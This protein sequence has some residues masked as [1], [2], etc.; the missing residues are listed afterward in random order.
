MW[1]VRPR[2]ISRSTGSR[3]AS[4]TGTD[5]LG[6]TINVNRFF[7]GHPYVL[8]LVGQSAPA[9]TKS[10]MRETDVVIAV[11]ASL[12]RR[13]LDG[14]TLFRDATIIQ[15]EVDALRERRASTTALHLIGRARQTVRSVTA[16]WEA[17]GLG[18]RPLD[19]APPPTFK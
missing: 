10:L 7:S 15:C 12:N 3:F 4:P 9:I 19:G 5:S 1:R 11:G 13:T 6:T 16:E 18:I 2:A 8:G 14:G 17:R